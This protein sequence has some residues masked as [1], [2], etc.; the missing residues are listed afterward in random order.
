MVQHLSNPNHNT[1]TLIDHVITSSHVAVCSVRQSVG[2][3]EHKW[4]ILI[5]WLFVPCLLECQFN[6]FGIVIWIRELVRFVPWMHFMILMTCGNFFGFPFISILDGFAPQKSVPSSTPKRATPWM[7]S[8]I[9]AAI[10]NKHRAK[11]S[12]K[13]TQ[14]AGY[15]S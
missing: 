7:V 9:L 14:S 3:S 4:W 6:H 1:A 12:C 11:K 5:C 15:C 8:A 13:I 10:K 2:M